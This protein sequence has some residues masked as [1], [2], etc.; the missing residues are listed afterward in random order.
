MATWQ[1]KTRGGLTGHRIFVFILQYLG[2]SPAYFLLC[3]VSFYYFIFSRKSN[4]SIY[5]YFRNIRHYSSI[6]ARKAVYCN[7]YT[8]RPDPDR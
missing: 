6:K 4:R 7:Y 1:G 5:S 8:L 3:F 2:L